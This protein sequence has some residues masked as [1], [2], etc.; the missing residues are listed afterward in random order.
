MPSR[1]RTVDP[2]LDLAL[3]NPRSKK[4]SQLLLA[5]HEHS[6]LELPVP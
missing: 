1:T 4:P 2:F 6:G 3:G 5:H